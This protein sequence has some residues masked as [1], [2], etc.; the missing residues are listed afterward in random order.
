M[1]D[2]DEFVR[3]F[4][5]RI[6]DEGGLGKVE[7]EVGAVVGKRERAAVAGE[8]GV[9]GAE[10]VV[11]GHSDDAGG[12]IAHE[13][14]EIGSG[15]A[16]SVPGNGGGE[17]D[18]PAVSADREGGKAGKA[19]VTAAAGKQGGDARGVGSAVADEE[20]LLGEVAVPGDEV[21]TIG[22]EQHDLPVMRDGRRAGVK[23]VVEPVVADRDILGD[24]GIE[25]ADEDVVIKVF[26]RMQGIEVGRVGGEDHTGAITADLGF[27]RVGEDGV[28]QIEQ[29]LLR[30]LAVTVDAGQHGKAGDPVED[31][32][33]AVLV[34]I[35]REDIVGGRGIGNVPSVRTDAGSGAGSLG[36]PAETTQADQSQI[37]SRFVAQEDIALAVAVSRDQSVERGIE[38]DEAPV[39]AEVDAGGAADPGGRAESVVARDHGDGIEES[40]ACAGQVNGGDAVAEDGRRRVGRCGKGNAEAGTGGG[41]EE[42]DRHE[43]EGLPGGEIDHC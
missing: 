17:R 12:E 9:L 3:V 24:P 33:V 27:G 8:S 4:V 32:D 21:R 1:P 35:G 36:G 11:V 40:S 43:G 26:R 34:G 30:L 2:V 42:I 22:G 18:G 5:R 39:G 10:D 28:L 20:I 13:D 19:V 41:R 23:A 7:G 16:G 14:V 38:D 37:A 31:K 6:R 29:L 15:V 25:V